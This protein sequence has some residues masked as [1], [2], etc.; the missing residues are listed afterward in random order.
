MYT[1]QSRLVGRCVLTRGSRWIPI[2]RWPE[3]YC[4]HTPTHS[5]H[6]LFRWHC[7]HPS[8]LLKNPMNIH[9]LSGS[10][11]IK[12]YL[13]YRR[14]LR[15]QQ[16]RQ[17]F[18]PQ[19]NRWCSSIDLKYWSPDSRRQRIRPPSACTWH[20][21]IW[22]RSQRWRCCGTLH[23]TNRYTKEVTLKQ[24]WSISRSTYFGGIEILL[25][26]NRRA[27]SSLRQTTD[28]E[29]NKNGYGGE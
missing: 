5:R 7:N 4:R 1:S 18:S 13:E 21:H 3:C 11:K 22:N 14:S 17:S 19:L 6:N 20:W 26:G 16:D 2:Y 8:D 25:R 28:R 15:A 27:F 29:N 12:V 10:Q 24:E 23:T 9:L